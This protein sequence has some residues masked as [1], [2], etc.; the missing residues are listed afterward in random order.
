MK[1]SFS[2]YLLKT[3]VLTFFLVVCSFQLEAQVIDTLIDVGGHRLHFN[4]I[5]GKGTP[6]LFESGGGSDAS[7]WNKLREHLKDSIDATLIAYDRAGF[8][9]S[10]MDTNRIDLLNEVK[11]LETALTQ[12]GYTK[13]LMLVPMSLGG[14]YSML[15]ASRNP[16]LVIG[17]V[18]IDIALPCFM[19]K[20]MVKEMILSMESLDRKLYPGHYYIKKNYEQ[21][22]EIMRQTI[23]PGNIP[24]VVI[25]SDTPPQIGAEGNNWKECQLSFGN[26][27][28]HSYLLAKN[29][30]HFQCIDYPGTQK[31]IIK[32]YNRLKKERSK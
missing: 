19:T 18:F 22:H 14:S 31:E 26:L 4:I 28:N 15:F 25:S 9:S 23:F 21:T 3:K 29:C 27:P 13:N 5:K 8:G 11:D 16:K 1:S 17:G 7:D 2:Q 30:N 6:I 32:L 12:L 10:E 24:T 20:E